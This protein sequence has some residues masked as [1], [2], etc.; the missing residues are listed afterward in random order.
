MSQSTTDHEQ[1]LCPWCGYPACSQGFVN[2]SE[3][4]KRHPNKHHQELVP[5]RRFPH[6]AL[7]CMDRSPKPCWAPLADEE[8]YI[9]PTQLQSEEADTDIKPP[10]PNMRPEGG[11]L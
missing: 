8:I 9:T 11:S 7:C 10:L 5:V 6:H 2:I 3:A 4:T 1:E